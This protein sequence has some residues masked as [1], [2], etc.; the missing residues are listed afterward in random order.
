MID[1]SFI[2]LDTKRN[3]SIKRNQNGQICNALIENSPVG[4]VLL[5]DGHFIF[6]NPAFCRMIGYNEDE[7]YLFSDSEINKLIYYK[8]REMLKRSIQNILLDSI[9]VS[10]LIV[11]IKRS[12][13]KFVWLELSL[14]SIRSGTNTYVQITSIDVTERKKSEEQFFYSQRIE[15][16][17][18]LT[19]GVA[20]QLSTP[21]AVISSRL[22]ILEDDLRKDGRY[23]Y[24][25]NLDKV[26]ESNHKISSIITRLVTF[27]RQ[28]HSTKTSTN[29]NHLLNEITG[30][31]N[32]SARRK[33]IRII[34]KLSAK[35]PPVKAFRNKLEQVFLNIIINAFDAMPSGGSIQIF[36]RLIKKNIPSVEICFKDSGIGMDKN[37]MNK[38]FEPFFS[39]KSSDKASGLGM[40]IS[41]S[42]IKEHNGNIVVKSSKAEGTQ[43]KVIIPV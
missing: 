19:A 41:Y 15:T 43:I 11:R 2:T 38:I 16:M 33:N 36:T 42:F 21:L 22:Q 13:G 28:S 40:F 1:S 27:L 10:S 5:N 37:V 32:E 14:N 4:F 17:G 39:T 6:V 35:V 3:T 20:H 34:N 23:N 8:D 18:Q 7:L 12:D 25:P 30:F 9:P 26:L 29:I 24:L 31:I